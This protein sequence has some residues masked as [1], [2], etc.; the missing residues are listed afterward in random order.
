V[1]QG[2]P[3]P[4]PPL[5]PL[6]PPM[7]ASATLNSDTPCRKCGYN[8]RGLNVSGRCPE[9]GA[10]ISI[11]VGGDLLRYSD[12]DWLQKLANGANLIVTGYIAIFLTTFVAGFFGILRLRSVLAVGTL[13]AV[14]A[15]LLVIVGAWL[16]TEPDPSGIGEDRYGTARRLIR[17]TLAI[18]IADSILRIITQFST[19]HPGVRLIVHS[20]QLAA[21]IATVI[22]FLAQLQYFSKLTQRIPDDSLTTRANFLKIALPV[23]YGIF[24]AFTVL[25]VVQGPIARGARALGPNPAF[26]L[27]GCGTAIVGIAV[28]V[29]FIMYLFLVA[30]SG[31][32]FKEQA[33]AARQ[34]WHWADPNPSGLTQA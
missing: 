23:T 25:T 30:R 7:S 15:G 31:R 10:A 14:A 21:G 1:T 34:M 18:G 26:L 3:P 22:G 9:C 11:S 17:I 33:H 13:V 19:L 12:P 2:T 32:S 5:P 28:L 16:V 6:P 27:F 4:S 8:L 20:L 29:F 24:V